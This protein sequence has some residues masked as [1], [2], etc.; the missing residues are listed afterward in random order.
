MDLELS[1]VVPTAIHVVFTD[2]LLL[3][4]M[5]SMSRVFTWV[6][7]FQENLVTYKVIMMA[8]E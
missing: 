3:D 6:K 8:I 4:M 1:F 7:L 5:R 2:N